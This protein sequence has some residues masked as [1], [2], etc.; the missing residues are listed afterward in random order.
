MIL[1]LYCSLLPWTLI[2]VNVRY[3][4]G[5]AKRS[6]ITVRVVKGNCT[7][8][9]HRSKQLTA[10]SSPIRGTYVGT[11]GDKVE[12]TEGQE[13]FSFLER[14]SSNAER[15]HAKVERQDAKQ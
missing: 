5:N 12:D 10:V 1:N 15:F 3:V 8:R 14:P 4:L 7:A 13:S 11:A 9:I 2:C 6:R